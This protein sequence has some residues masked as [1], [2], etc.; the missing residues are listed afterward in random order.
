MVLRTLLV[1]RAPG[2]IR[3][4]ELHAHAFSE[5]VLYTR[6]KGALL[7]AGDERPMRARRLCLLPPGIA[8]GEFSTGGFGSIW[9]QFEG[10][11]GREH[12]PIVVDDPAHGPCRHLMELLYHEYLFDPRSAICRDALVLLVGVVLR[13]A[14]PGEGDGRVEAM[15]HLLIRNI[16]NPDFRIRD[17]LFPGHGSPAALHGHFKKAV[18]MSPLQYLI[19]LRL[20]ESLTLLRTPGMTLANVA[21]QVGFRDPFHFS[22]AFKQKMG[23]SP[24][25]YRAVKGR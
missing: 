5:I 2:P 23:E 11:Q 24:S 3:G 8:H 16:S 14:A 21:S 18:G 20:R 22:R 19:D 7:F 6:G 13:M 12:E 17:D 1:N 25:Q 4:S 10:F 15:K 9:V